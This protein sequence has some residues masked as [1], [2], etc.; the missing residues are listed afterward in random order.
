M[1]RET[2]KEGVAGRM[3]SVCVTESGKPSRDEFGR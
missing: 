1:T 3:A 2:H